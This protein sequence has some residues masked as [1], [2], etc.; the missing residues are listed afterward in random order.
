VVLNPGA[1]WDSRLWP[2]DRFAEVAFQ[3]GDK[4][5][6]PSVVIWAGPRERG[7][8]EQIVAAAG[9][10]A[11]LAPRTSLKCLAELLRHA[12]LYVG[13]DTGPTHL[14]AAVGTPCVCLCGTTR[15]EVSGPFG[16]A[17]IIVQAYYQA[18][19]SRE[20][21]A[22]NNDAMLAIDVDRVW[23]ACRRLLQPSTAGA[24]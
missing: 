8:A 21:R 1:G 13:S 12:C 7:W 15:G 3:L 11:V 14:A 17:H 20:R 16:S 24:A 19:T 23:S 9:D 22:A 6:L 5:G 10:H 4:L 18:G 2:T